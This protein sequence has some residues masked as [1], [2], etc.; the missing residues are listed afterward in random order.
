[1]KIRQERELTRQEMTTIR[2]DDIPVD[3]F[4]IPKLERE[5]SMK[6]RSAG[7]W[8]SWIKWSD[9]RESK[10]Q[11]RDFVELARHYSHEGG[12]IEQPDVPAMVFDR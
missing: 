5:Y 11:I 7:H 3:S 8:K 10:K 6:R 9:K 2:K 1:M 4:N 12:K